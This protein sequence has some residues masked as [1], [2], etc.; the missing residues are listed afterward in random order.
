MNLLK[1]LAAISSMTMLSRITGLIRDMLF[2]AYFG[3][4]GVM[5][6][7]VQAFKIPNFFR[8]MF[9]EGAFSQ[10]F[11]PI[12]AEYKNQTSDQEVKELIDHVATVLVWALL[13][14]CVLGVLGAPL[15]VLMFSSGFWGTP[16]FDL[17]VNLTRIMFPYIGFMSLVAL[18]SGILNTW[19]RFKIPAFTPVLL[20]LSLIAGTVFSLHWFDKAHQIYA[21]AVA[22]FVGGLLQLVIQIPS[23]VQIGMLPHLSMNPLFALRDPKVRRVLRQMGPAVLAVSATQ[24][25]IMINSTWASFLP[26]GSASQ[27]NFA[28]RLMEFPS[29]MLGVAL[30]TVLLPSL[31]SAKAK[32]DVQEY[33]ALLDWGLRLTFLLAL[34]AAVGLLTLS[35]GLTATL[36]HRGHF[37]AHAVHETAR[38]VAAYGVGL[39]G[40]IVVK[41]LAPGFYAHQ[42][43]RTPVKIALVVLVVTQLL[44]LAFVPFFQQAGL[45]LSVGLGAC[46]NAAL[47]YR[48]L[49]QRALYTPHSGWLMFFVKL[50]VALSL[51]AGL[52][53]F[54]S[55]QIDW[56]ALKHSNWLRAAIMAGVIG[57]CVLV[58]FSALIAM[59]FRLRDFRKISH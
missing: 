58:Y 34:P 15:L 18:S 31:S 39:A 45:A 55:T 49:R 14:T 28:D 17:T 13:F 40:L 50:G 57:T 35:E 11:V 23:L 44:N 25:S 37:D 53:L 2:G 42:D 8:R 12:L 7:Y 33:S 32:Q 54:A 46:V 5:D 29:A 26:A 24:I 43:I 16:N 20:N 59:G 6:A 36:F 56:L 21:L 9:A 19:R 4:G 48:G 52:A 30:G 38:A 41:I 3:A 10:A 1:T 47:L 51:M 27:L 22:V